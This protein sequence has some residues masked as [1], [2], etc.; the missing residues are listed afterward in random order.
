MMETSENGID[1]RGASNA[2]SC[3][4][5]LFLLRYFENLE[6]FAVYPKRWLFETNEVFLDDERL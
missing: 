3:S 1:S 4:R 5:S 6:I 2:F